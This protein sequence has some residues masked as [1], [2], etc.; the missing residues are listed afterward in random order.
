MANQTITRATELRSRLLRF[1]NSLPDQKT[2]AN[3]LYNSQDF[4]DLVIE[5]NQAQMSDGY[6]S[7]GKPLV[8]DKAELGLPY[9]FGYAKLKRKRGISIGKRANLYLSGG[10][11]AKM[12]LTKKE[13]EFQIKVE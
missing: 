8:S 2:I 1:R 6:D 9:T 11:Y 4:R 10:L 7:M 13:T 5:L 12:Y 3:W